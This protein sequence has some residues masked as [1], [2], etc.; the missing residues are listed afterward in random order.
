VEAVTVEDLSWDRLDALVDTDP[1]KLRDI[2]FALVSEQDRICTR[3]VALAEEY[4]R[5]PRL[6]S[7]GAVAG[8]LREWVGVPR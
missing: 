1:L 2:A 8:M 3:V 4:E 6:I 7:S 5:E